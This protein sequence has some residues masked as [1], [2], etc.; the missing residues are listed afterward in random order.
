M[1]YIFRAV[2]L[3]CFA[4]LLLACGQQTET[5]AAVVDEVKDEGQ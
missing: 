3:S 4:F 5:A 2:T 1:L